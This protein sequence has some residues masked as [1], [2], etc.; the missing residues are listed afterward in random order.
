MDIIISF[1]LVIVAAGLFLN[2]PIQVQVTHTHQYP[3]Q[4]NTNVQ[5]PENLKDEMQR[6]MDEALMNLNKFLGVMS[7]DE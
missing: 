6:G 2:K 4:I 7:D 3:D 1:L 5:E